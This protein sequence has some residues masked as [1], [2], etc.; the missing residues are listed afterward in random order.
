MDLRK[1]PF[2]KKVRKTDQLVLADGEFGNIVARAHP[3]S[4]SAVLRQIFF[5]REYEPLVH[6]F[7][8]QGFPMQHLHIIDAGANVGYTSRYLLSNFPGS[9]IVCIEPDD[10]NAKILEQNLSAEI[11][12]GQVHV[13][14]KALMD[15]DDVNI[16][17]NR[18]FRD[19]KDYAIAVAISPNRTDLKSITTTSLMKRHGWEYIDILKIDIEGAERYVFNATADLSF[20]ENVKVIAIEIHDEFGI[21]ESI[22]NILRKKDFILFRNAET[23]FGINNRFLETNNHR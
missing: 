19:G 2:F 10:E 18:N 14:R 4:D 1:S 15:L 20:L 9:T 6:I 8:D 5:L 13:Y 3:H 16:E 7:L 21:R 17:T 12:D 23:T 22:N 11:E